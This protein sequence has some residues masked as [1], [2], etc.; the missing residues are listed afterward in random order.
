MPLT[1]KVIQQ[2]WRKYVVKY[3]KAKHF[4]TFLL[5]NMSH[6]ICIFKDGIKMATKISTFRIFALFIITYYMQALFII[7]NTLN[8]T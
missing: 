3:K 1:L 4:R 8:K 7:A 5:Q 6:D 2:G